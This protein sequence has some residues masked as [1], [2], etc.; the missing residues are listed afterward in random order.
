MIRANKQSMAE[1]TLQW[2]YIP[3]YL[4][5]ILFIIC[6]LAT[7]KCCILSM[8]TDAAEYSA[9]YTVQYKTFCYYFSW[10]NTQRPLYGMTSAVSS[11]HLMSVETVTWQSCIV[12]KVP[13][14]STSISWIW[15]VC[16]CTVEA[17]ESS[18]WIIID[19]G[20]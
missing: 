18:V 12:T 19:L 1:N 2:N 13:V 17:S 9:I 5:L 4:I 16:I 7:S 20:Y 14:A 11:F 3:V 8:L 6:I 10:T 15:Y